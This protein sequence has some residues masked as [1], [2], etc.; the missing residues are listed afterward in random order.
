MLYLAINGPSQQGERAEYTLEYA[1]THRPHWS[2][3]TVIANGVSYDF[4]LLPSGLLHPQAICLIG[5]G[6]VVHVPTF[7]KEMADLEAKGL[8]N[9]RDRLLVSDR[10][11]IITDCHIQVDGLE[12]QELGGNSIGTTKR[13]IGPTYSTMAARNGITISEM[14][15]EEVF[16]RKLRQLAT[17]FKKRFGDLLVYDI[18]D[19]IKRFKQ[20]REDLRLKTF[21]VD[22]VPIMADAQAKN[23]K[24]LVEGAQAVM[25]DL[26]FGT[27]PFVTSSNTGLGGVFTGLGLNP[28]KINHIVGVVKAYT[29]RVGGGAFPT[30]Q[31]NEVGE[32]LGK[33]GHEIGVSTGRSRRCGWLDLVVVKYSANLNHYTA[34]NL[35][36]L[37]ILD[38]FP[39]IKVAVAYKDKET[40]EELPS[41]PADLKTLEKAEVVYKELEGWNTPTTGAKTYFDLPKQARAYIEFI[42]E[43]VGVKCVWIGT[44]PKREDLIS[45]A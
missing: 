45:R 30:E 28:R 15:D 4:H 42:E 39:T 7:F 24:I 17:G 1:Y 10:C 43:F 22:A 8:K 26:N 12:E 5:S 6:A 18:E 38:T 13:G 19:E 32:K 14:F 37:D 33:I 16:E 2:G 29:T 41:F 44:G 9:I 3:H 36:K 40:G 34:L 20:Y 23:T 25:L 11:H 21:V 31:L 35:T 27:Y